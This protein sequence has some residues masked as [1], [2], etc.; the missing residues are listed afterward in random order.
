V[1]VVEVVEV[2]EAVVTAALDTDEVEGGCG[3][4]MSED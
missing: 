1:E 3:G 4:G 2:V